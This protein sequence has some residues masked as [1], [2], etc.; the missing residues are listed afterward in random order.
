MMTIMMLEDTFLP[1]LIFAL[2]GLMIGSF[3]NV[4][5]YRLPIMYANDWGLELESSHPESSNI[6][7]DTTSVPKTSP[8]S[9]PINPHAFNLAVPASACPNCGNT[10]KW[11]HN[12]PLL[13]FIVLK[14]RCGFCKTPV[15]WRYPFIELL[16][17]LLYL[18][19]FFVYGWSLTAV[20]WAGFCTVVLVA[21]GID[22][23]TQ[24]LPDLLT[25]PLVWAGLI[26][27]NLQIISTPLAQSLWGAVIGYL[28]LWSVFW[29]FKWLTGKEGMGYGDFKFL[30][31]FGAWMGP[32]A[33]IPLLLLSCTVGAVVGILLR[34][35][36]ALGENQ[37][38]AFG[39][40]LA[41]AALIMCFTS[42]IIYRLIGFQ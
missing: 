30:A 18:A 4:V 10:L 21:A 22:W 27:S 38:I 12:L 2:L 37:A 14:G 1:P 33:I 26:L 7:S 36:G 23:D 25:L 42:P 11:W 6:N 28:V 29:L 13:S 31:A 5:I 32:F 34:L 9:P 15:S 16:T 39:P 3:L 41:M 19:C 8:S 17:C 20:A 40:Y 24:I 35:K